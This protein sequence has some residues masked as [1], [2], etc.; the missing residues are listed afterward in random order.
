MWLRW[1]LKSSLL[2]RLLLII[3]IAF[4]MLLIAEDHLLQRDGVLLRE[5]PGNFYLV[6]EVLSR[7][8]MVTQIDEKYGWLQVRTK[9]ISEG[10][11]SANAIIAG[12]DTPDRT[13]RGAVPTTV[14]PEA[15]GAMIKG[16][17]AQ[18][19]VNS[20]D[21]L[22]LKSIPPVDKNSVEEFRHDFPELEMEYTG[23][24][25]RY[26]EEMLPEYLAFSPVLTVAVLEEWGGHRE[27]LDGY[28]GN[29]IL[30][31]ADRAQANSLAPRAFIAQQ[32][33]NAISL[34][35]GWIVI[36]GELFDL[37][38][39]EAELAGILAHEFAHILYHHSYK[40][41]KEN[42]WRFYVEE[43]FDKL[44]EET[45]GMD[46][47]YD[48][49]QDWDMSELEDF[50]NSVR[51]TAQRRH[52][53]PMELQADSAATVFLAR[54]GYQPDALL[55]VLQRLRAQYGDRL[56]GHGD[57]TIAWLSSRDELDQRIA[58]L[59]KQVNKLKKKYPGDAYTNRFQKL[60]RK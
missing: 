53:L 58:K 47:L 31:I 33:S 2:L 57:L 32:G 28:V 1:S 38:C 56:T 9:P 34:P 23:G 30:W 7:G 45:A 36:G 26:G 25:Y 60:G 37:L 13:V 18:T 5:G 40:T 42:A 46:S 20:D 10:W 41:L 8:Q 16:L 4:P 3:G 22:A 59:Q 6:L 52:D 24:A 35:G 14:R 51:A 17:C 50:A 21:A 54:C 39:D 44:A 43:V 12:T 27:E 11:I 55:R 19:H 15:I 49:T 29:I 48:H